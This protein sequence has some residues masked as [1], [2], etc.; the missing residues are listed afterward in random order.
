MRI[1]NPRA[2]LSAH[3][4]QKDLQSKTL[5]ELEEDKKIIDE[6]LEVLRETREYL[7][8]SAWTHITKKLLPHIYGRLQRDRD[9]LD[10]AN[11]KD[12]AIMTGRILQLK[13]LTMLCS[14]VNGEI[15]MVEEMAQR[16]QRAIERKMERNR[17]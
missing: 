6:K 2:M 17:T 9:D 11:V 14:D 7:E 10:P 16:Y 15:S 5:P 1:P 12:Q 8:S 13:D 4:F 3:R